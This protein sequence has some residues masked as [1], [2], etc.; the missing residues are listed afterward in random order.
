MAARMV[1]NQAV[2]RNQITVPAEINA[3]AQ[4]RRKIRPKPLIA[5][6][7]T[8]RGVNGCHA[9]ARLGNS[10]VELD[11]VDSLNGPFVMRGCARQAGGGSGLAGGGWLGLGCCGTTRTVTGYRNFITSS[12]MTS[13]Q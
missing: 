5:K 6:A 12:T 4:R 7:A 2:W 10:E 9:A 3:T 8:P 13:M 1:G 11:S